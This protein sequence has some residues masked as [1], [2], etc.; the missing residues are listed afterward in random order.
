M[1]YNSNDYSPE[2]ST[3]ISGPGHVES[4]NP[5]NCNTKIEIASAT[6]VKPETRNSRKQKK[7]L[8]Q[9]Y[10]S[11]NG[12]YVKARM[13]QPLTKCRNN[14]QEKISDEDKE[15]IFTNYWKL[16]NHRKRCAYVSSMLSANYKASHRPKYLDVEKQ[17]F[18]Q[19]TYKYFLEIDGKRIHVCKI[20]FMKTLDESLSFVNLVA[21]KKR[22]TGI[23]CPSKKYI[24][25]KTK[26][27]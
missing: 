13:M 2:L 12:K 27:V 22:S 25:E 8:G 17:R 18:R 4:N 16:G 7:N 24:T 20:C 6:T 26:V 19:I 9:P 23:D 3:I 21:I 5:R 14:C 10:I 15:T 11:S 1:E